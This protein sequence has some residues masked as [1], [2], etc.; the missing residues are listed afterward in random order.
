MS[1]EEQPNLIDILNKILSLEYS[2][3]VFYPRL[4]NMV[5]DNEAKKL[6]Q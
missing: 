2:L 5:K 4:A 1:K 3:I 6:T